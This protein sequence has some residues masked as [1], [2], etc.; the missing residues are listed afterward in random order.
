MPP[1]PSSLVIDYIVILEIHTV[2]KTFVLGY[3]A[4]N[5]QNVSIH[6]VFRITVMSGLRQRLTVGGC[7]GIM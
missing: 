3:I 6:L 5:Y 1:T 2:H 7:I 4:C